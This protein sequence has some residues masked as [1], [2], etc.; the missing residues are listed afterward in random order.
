MTQKP[1]DGLTISSM[2]E[3]ASKL[4]DSGG[5]KCRHANTATSTVD[6]GMAVFGG[7]IGATSDGEFSGRFGGGTCNCGGRIRESEGERNS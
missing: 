6:F 7:G 1:L 2:S 3:F 5:T 4:E